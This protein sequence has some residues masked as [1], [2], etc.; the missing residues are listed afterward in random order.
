MA[1]AVVVVLLVVGCYIF[2]LNSRLW[3][4]R[5]ISNTIF[6]LVNVH[7]VLFFILFSDQ[8]NNLLN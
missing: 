1:L 6:N 7:L 8:R 2:E 4:I 5:Y 3:E